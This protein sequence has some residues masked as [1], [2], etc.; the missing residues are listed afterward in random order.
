MFCNGV[1]RQAEFIGAITNRDL[2]AVIGQPTFSS[3]LSGVGVRR[4]RRLG[5]ENKK[6]FARL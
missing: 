2:P 5:F 6:S 4:R 1:V 3:W